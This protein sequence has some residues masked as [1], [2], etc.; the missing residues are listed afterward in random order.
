MNFS[1]LTFYCSVVAIFV[2]FAS[3]LKADEIIL[4]VTGNTD[5]SAAG[6][7][8]FTLEQFEALGLSKIKTSTPWHEDVV[9]FEGVPGHAFIKFMGSHGTEID[10]IAIN[11]YKVTIPI[12]D[13]TENGLIFATRKNSTPMTIREKGPVFAIYPFD[14]HEKINNDVYFSRAIWQIKSLHFK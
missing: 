4:T 12:I 9:E 5:R 11:D 2:F 13:L 1:R 8:E 6:A 7:V 3:P 10:A 14:S